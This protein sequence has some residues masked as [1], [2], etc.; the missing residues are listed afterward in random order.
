MEFDPVMVTGTSA[1]VWRAG[2]IHKK[3]ALRHAPG[4]RAPGWME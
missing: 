4:L 2:N 1:R 3:S